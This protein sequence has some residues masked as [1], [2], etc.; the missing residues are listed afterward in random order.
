MKIWSRKRCSSTDEVKEL[1]DNKV[2]EQVD[3]PQWVANAVLVKKE[4]N[5]WRF[6]I[7]FIDLNNACL[8][9]FFPMFSLVITKSS[10]T[11]TINNIP[12]S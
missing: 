2:I 9:D 10:C 11:R 4:N 3:H 6:C 8:N 7:D 12:L 1:L 5:S